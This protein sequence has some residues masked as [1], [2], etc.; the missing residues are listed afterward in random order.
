MTHSELAI[1]ISASKTKYYRELMRFQNSRFYMKIEK[2][3]ELFYLRKILKLFDLDLFV[4][5]FKRAER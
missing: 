1:Q 5:V 3:L 4:L 2:A